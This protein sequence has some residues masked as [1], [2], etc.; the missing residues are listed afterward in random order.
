VKDDEEPLELY[1]A[2]T[3]LH[4]QAENTSYLS[5]LL[6]ANW[7]KRAKET[8]NDKKKQELQETSQ[9]FR[10]LSSSAGKKAEFAMEKAEEL[11]ES[12]DFDYP[13]VCYHFLIT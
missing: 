1:N 4:I 13:E 6:A 2:Y 5:K 9:V 11:R 12:Y 10:N 3:D 8:L 7:A